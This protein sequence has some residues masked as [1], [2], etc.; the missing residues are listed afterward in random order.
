ME[1]Y[2]NNKIL[3]LFLIKNFRLKQNA[4]EL[5]SEELKIKKIVFLR[6]F[7]FNFVLKNI[8]KLVKTH[9]VKISVYLKKKIGSNKNS[10]FFFQKIKNYF[11]KLKFAVLKMQIGCK[12]KKQRQ[13]K[14]KKFGKLWET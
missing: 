3:L 7:F 8:Y 2:F 12:V 4:H 9:I 13:R 6:F 11:T 14:I 1:G 10:V 5:Q